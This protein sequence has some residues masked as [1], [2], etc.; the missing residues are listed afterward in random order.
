MIHPTADVSPRA[1]VASDAKIWHYVQIREDAQIGHNCIIGKA[2]YVDFGVH[3]GDNCKL[4]NGVKVY[5]GAT[6]EDGV[7]LGPQACVLNDKHPRAITPTGELKLDADWEVGRV[8]IRFGA[9]VGAGALILPNVTVG[10][11]ALVAAGA[12]VTSNVPAHALVAGTPARLRGYVCQCGQRLE[13]REE[14]RKRIWV[15]PVD[16]STYALDA[17]G[18]MERTL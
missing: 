14:N 2:V 15:C 13:E 11:F 3:I 5:H 10:R 17:N 18:E 1:L 7:F 8:L 16:N 12:V 6:L 9:S 4:Q